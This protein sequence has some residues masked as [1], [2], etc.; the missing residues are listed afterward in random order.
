MAGGDN[1]N[2]CVIG[3]G[4]ADFAGQVDIIG[5]G[6][7]PL[8]APF[9]P[10]LL[11]GVWHIADSKASL[12]A[13]LTDARLFSTLPAEIIALTPKGFASPGDIVLCEDSLLWPPP[14]WSKTFLTVAEI[15]AAGPALHL[16]GGLKHQADTKANLDSKLTDANLIST[17]PGEI[18]AIALKPSPVPA[19]LLLIEDSGAAFA[20]KRITISSLPV[21]S[22]TSG[23]YAYR[24]GANITIGP[25]SELLIDFNQKRDDTLN[26]FALATDIFTAINAGRYQFNASCVFGMTAAG[27]TNLRLKHNGN[28]IITDGRDAATGLIVLNVNVTVKLAAGDTVAVYGFQTS[29]INQ[30][31]ATN[32][33]T[34]NGGQF[35][36]V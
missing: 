16:L 24:T 23:F 35:Q 25:S 3:N 28:V 19:D 5:N 31:I 1:C 33:L 32:G 8:S 6:A 26:E 2:A 12:D 30:V 14:T 15:N 18:A 34:F 10:H 17:R 4:K 29:A 9:V 36:G 7:F 21:A 13:K 22:F 27:A 20:K 11:G